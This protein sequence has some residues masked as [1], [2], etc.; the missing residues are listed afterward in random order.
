MKLK[1]LNR[2]ALHVIEREP[3]ITKAQ[4]ARILDISI[5]TFNYRIKNGN[6]TWENIKSLRLPIHPSSFKESLEKDL[7]AKL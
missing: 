6:L 3:E 4:C 1:H 2:L 5:Q 7:K